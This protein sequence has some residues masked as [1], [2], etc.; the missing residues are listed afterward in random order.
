MYLPIFD[1]SCF[2]NYLFLNTNFENFYL[3]IYLVKGFKY[4]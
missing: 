3:S 1:V 4:Y 2:L